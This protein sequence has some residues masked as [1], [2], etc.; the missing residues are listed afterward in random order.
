MHYLV[1]GGAGFIGSHLVASLLADGHDVTVIDDLS[2]GK[3]ENLPEEAAFIEGNIVNKEAI[4]AATSSVAGVF[5]LAAVA[6][7]ERS[8]TEW[9]YTHQVNLTGIVNLFE[10]IAECGN[11]IPVVYASSAA[12]FGDNPDMPL[13]EA[14]TT[15]PLTAYGADKLGCEQHAK[16]AHVVHGIPSLGL[17]FFNVYGPRQDP[18]SPYSGVVSIFAKRIGEGQDITIFGD[19]EQT[20][21]FVFV[22]DVVAALRSS[23]G[24]LEGNDVSQ[25][26]CHV[27][28]GKAVSL[29]HLADAIEEATGNTVTRH[30]A[31]ARTGDIRHSLGD[32]SKLNTLLGVIAETPLVEGLKQTIGSV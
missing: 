20:R 8:R 18:S 14:S 11:N 7:V 5:H 19:G 26:V 23:M 9:V 10:S 21:D 2:T 6:S 27:C 13:S 24:K 15:N 1:T 22:A 16:V 30:F 29:L 25:G 4:K 32:P 3:R 31:E 17:R 28:T 12:V